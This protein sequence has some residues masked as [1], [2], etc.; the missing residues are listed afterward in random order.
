MQTYINYN[1]HFAVDFIDGS[2]VYSTG[3]TFGLVPAEKPVAIPPAIRG[4]MLTAGSGEW[5]FYLKDNEESYSQYLDI[6]GDIDRKNFT[7]RLHHSPDDITEYEEYTAFIT[8]G[9]P[10]TD[11]NHTII[12]I[13]AVL[14]PSAAEW[15]E[16][17]EELSITFEVDQSTSYNTWE[18]WHLIPDVPLIIQP[19]AVKEKYVDIPGRNGAI[20]LT[21]AVVGK[22]RFERMA[23]EFI[24]T[25]HD[26]DPDKIY[27]DICE[28]LHGQK[29]DEV[30]IAGKEYDGRWTVRSYEPDGESPKIVLGYNL[31]L[32]SWTSN[33]VSSPSQGGGSV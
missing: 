21:E 22:P 29:F 5:R 13:S 23:G 16:H 11:E 15:A 26:N 14:Y 8:V 20:D 12:T 24:F 32:H 10:Q 3:S 28:K 30:T 19:P 6:I 25:I 1:G 9:A 17:D 31:I 7:V 4:G 33:E 2:T 27:D 18:D